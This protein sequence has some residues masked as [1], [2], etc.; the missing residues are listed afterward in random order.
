MN[1]T[2][3][4]AA[5]AR[6][7]GW[8][9][10]CTGTDPVCP[11]TVDAAKTVAATFVL[12][13]YAVVVQKGGNGGGRVTGQPGNLDCGSTCSNLYDHGT[14]TTLTATADANS[15]FSGWQG[16]CTNTTVTCTVTVDGAKV[17]T[18]TF[19][20]KQYPLAIQ[21]TGT[22]AGVIG[23]APGGG[24]CR[25]SCTRQFDHGTVV[26]LTATAALSSTFTGWQGACTGS[27]PSCTLTMTAAQ[28]VTATFTLKQYAVTVT[29]GGNGTGDVTSTPAGID[30]GLTCAQVLQYGARLTLTATAADNS[31]FVGWQG[32][33]TGSNPVCTITVNAAQ[34]VTATFA[35][36]QYALTVVRNGNGHGVVSSNP[37]GIACGSSCT[38]AL[39]Y[40]TQITLTATPLT[41]T[42][43]TGW[44]GAC[45]G[46]NPRCVITFTGANVV[47]A[48]F[49][50][51]QYALSVTR[52]GTGAGVVTSI[53]PGLDCGLTCTV[54]LN[55]GTQV[56]LTATAAISSTFTGWQGACT[57]QTPVCTV[58]LDRAQ[59]I[60]AT[61][62]LNL[63]DLTVA[64]SGKGG[65]VIT[66]S[67]AGIDCGLTCTLRAQ[68][69]TVI[70]LTA[71][72]DAISSFAG[73]Q[74][75]CSGVA[76][77]CTVSLTTAQTVTATF[78]YQLYPL[79]I[80]KDGS[81]AGLVS[82][83]PSAIDC[84]ITCTASV[85]YGT[86]LTLTTTTGAR[87]A[88]AGWSGACT[89]PDLC[90]VTM[91][92]A[93][94]ITATF[95]GVPVASLAASI[96]TTP[97]IA[98]AGQ[99]VTY[100]YWITNTGDLSVTIAAQSA[101]VGSPRLLQQPDQ[102]VLTATS[103]LQP[104][105]AAMAVQVSAAPRCNTEVPWGDTLAVTG[106]TA[107]GITTTAQVSITVPLT[108][109]VL[110]RQSAKANTIYIGCTIQIAL[111]RD[112][113]PAYDMVVIVGTA[114]RGLVLEG[115]QSIQ[116]YRDAFTLQ[117]QTNALLNEG[118]P[119]AAG[120]RTIRRLRI[121]QGQ[122]NEV[123]TITTVAPVWRLFMPLVRK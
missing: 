23:L 35:L 36:N 45:T 89:G 87:S 119:T 86:V 37:S 29:K 43:F 72:A 67:P 93:K 24:S 121:E 13:Q 33:C 54:Q 76:P 113:A 123:E 98:A 49:T 112:A 15:L 18:A 82:S 55:H 26:T 79:T 56:T 115:V 111:G 25:S 4:P 42:L 5:G 80:T 62:A 6:F 9:G 97:T 84:G 99:P 31:T 60:T 20:L 94:A 16:A 101:N 48:T 32:A 59:A 71:T 109:S 95:S 46:V 41:D 68:Y 57:G 61:F 102:T 91:D 8:S 114:P 12:K 40:G 51:K 104:G 107:G 108:A 77:V 38:V 120:C 106:T 66:S 81:G 19:T 74:G 22:G 52:V 58:T 100:T 103:Y 3:T 17:V 116:S 69:G 53:P 65:G 110:S 50:L 70:T 92:A 90:V 78:R 96:V 7:A 105:A 28:A 11:V 34:P 14:V 88:F 85:E 83:L 63:Y 27:D 10:A 2:A 73:W 39:D 64:K 30:C 44:Q 47:T 21:S 122:I 1:L 75:A 118:C 117:E